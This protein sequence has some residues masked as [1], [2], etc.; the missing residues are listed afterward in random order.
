[1]G[2]W[3]DDVDYEARE[4]KEYKGRFTIN[5]KKI[6]NDVEE[7]SQRTLEVTDKHPKDSLLLLWAG[8]MCGVFLFFIAAYQ[9]LAFVTIPFLAFYLLALIRIGK[10]WKGYHYSMA[11]YLLMSIGTVIALFAVSK[12]IHALVFDHLG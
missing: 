3:G 5:F 6:Y 10:A 1:M 7:I 12:V 11:Q 8:A 4:L 9:I 2:N